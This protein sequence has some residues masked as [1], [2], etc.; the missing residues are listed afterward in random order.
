MSPLYLPYVS[1]RS[2]LYL[3]EQVLLRLVVGAH[4]RD[5]GAAPAAA[6]RAADAVAVDLVRVREKGLKQRVRVG[7]GVTVGVGVGLGLGLR[8]GFGLGV[9]SAVDLDRRG[10]V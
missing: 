6:R 5:G 10:Q 9:E 3:R 1:P 7:V 2:A 4:E 8:C